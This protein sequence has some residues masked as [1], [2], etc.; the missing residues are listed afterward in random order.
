VNAAATPRAAI[1]ITKRALTLSLGE[2]GDLLLAQ[3]FLLAAWWDVRRRP[4][5][6][7]LSVVNQA[8]KESGP[9]NEERLSRLALAVNRVASYGLFRPTCLVRAVALERMIH[10]AKAGSAVVRVGVF[11]GA[12]QFLA[13]AWIEL[14]QR[15]LG[16]RPE[17]V[18][19]FTPLHDFTALRP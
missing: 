7:L 15:V 19:Q 12:G 18:R 6:G 13:H 14:D 8:P 10:Y 1:R 5:G 4:V 9:R 3:W 17:R 16:D 2:L 11:Q